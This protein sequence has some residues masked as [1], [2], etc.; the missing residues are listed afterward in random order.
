MIFKVNWPEYRRK[1][2]LSRRGTMAQHFNAKAVVVGFDAR[3]TSRA[4][5]NS[6]ARIVEDA[7]ADVFDIGLAGTKEM[8]W[9]A[10]EFGTCAGIEVTTSYNPINYNGM[11]IVKSGS[12][13]LDDTVGFQVIKRLVET[14]TWVASKTHGTI[15]D[16]VDDARLA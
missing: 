10:T 12:C 16:Y 13:T 4:F 3:E 14:E 8:Y 11:K 6:P 5:A 1:H 7:G 15:L 2:C 9:A